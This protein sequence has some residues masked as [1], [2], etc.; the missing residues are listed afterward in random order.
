MVETELCPCGAGDPYDV[1]CWRFHSGLVRPETAE[2]LMRSRY[3]AY[4]K[5]DVSYLRATLWPQYQK[6]FNELGTLLRAQDSRWLGLE[7]IASDRGQVTDK[8]GSVVFVARSVVDGVAH[9]Q[10]EK[11]LFR[12]KGRQWYYVK[13]LSE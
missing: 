10:R 12:K 4:V 6:S 8:E 9:E 3:S 5:Q 7:I 11:S 2:L 1:C 13:A